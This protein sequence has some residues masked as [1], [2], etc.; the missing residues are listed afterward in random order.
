MFKFSSIFSAVPTIFDTLN[1]TMTEENWSDVLNSL[2]K[3]KEN[4]TE[5]FIQ[6][7]S[8]S[9]EGILIS[10]SDSNSIEGYDYNNA[11]LNIHRGVKDYV[12]NYNI[13]SPH[14]R[15]ITILF[16]T[17]SRPPIFD[18]AYSTSLLL[19]HYRDE[20]FDELIMD[21][22]TNEDSSS[23]NIDTDILKHVFEDYQTIISLL[24]NHNINFNLFS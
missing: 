23:C 4:N 3:F 15:P 19:H 7:T 10:I 18:D 24:D 12:L 21:I 9:V 1:G 20:S 16:D 8:A 11:R 17:K 2:E 13:L 14:V 5:Y 22:M 6:I